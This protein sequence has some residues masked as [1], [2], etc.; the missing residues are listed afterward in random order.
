MLEDRCI[1]LFNRVDEYV[2]YLWEQSSVPSLSKVDLQLADIISDSF[3][4]ILPSKAR[5][6]CCVSI[7]DNASIRKNRSE[8][9]KFCEDHQE[10]RISH[11]QRHEDPNMR[12]ISI[13][14]IKDRTEY[15]H[16]KCA[17]GP[18]KK[19]FRPLYAYVMEQRTLMLKD[20]ASRDQSSKRS[21]KS[22]RYV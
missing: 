21:R 6:Q 16:V 15:D 9:L 1:D 13:C 14:L 8:L 18:M 17:V 7:C 22:R 10:L 11:S 12:L 5:S 20:Q 3:Q 4:E 19:A 2:D